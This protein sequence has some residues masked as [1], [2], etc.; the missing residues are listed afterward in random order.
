[1]KQ[2]QSRTV[3]AG[4]DATTDAQIPEWFADAKRRQNVTVPERF[5]AGGDHETNLPA[6]SNQEQTDLETDG[7]T[8]NANAN[9]NTNADDDVGAHIPTFAE[10]I[11][12]LPR[13]T[14]TEVAY[15]N[16]LTGEW[17]ETNRFTALVDPE[18]IEEQ[19]RKAGVSDEADGD[20][21]AGDDPLFHVPS[22]NYTIINPSQVYSP[23]ETVLRDEEYDDGT[24]N[25]V[26]LGDIVFGEIRQYRRGGEVHMDLMFNGMDVD[27]P[28]RARDADSGG[29]AAGST[30]P[31]TMGLTT[32]YDFFGGQAVYVEG[33]AQDGYCSNSIRSL[34]DKQVVRH[35][36]EVNDFTEWWEAILEEVQLLSN[37]L[38]DLIIDAQEITVDFREVPFGVTDL[39]ELL[40]LPDYLAAR[41][42]DD[43]RANAADPFEMD[44]W[45][46]Y[47]GGTY[48]LSHFYRGREGNTLDA[49]SRTINDLLMN[50]AVSVSRIKDA[51]ITREANRDDEQDSLDA[52]GLKAATADIEKLET[53]VQQ[54]ADEYNERQEQ[55]RQ[56]LTQINGDDAG[57][58]NGNGNG[59]A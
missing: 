13:A 4:L 28:E 40:D 44:L 47:S 18:R 35:F 22:H 52:E 39:Y 27:L 21:S 32:G 3:F 41:A 11:R 9:A 29:H 46:L 42:A 31:L 15:R 19:S 8:A 10:A 7:G 30:A 53:S 49:H 2:P 34:T 26:S 1:M 43:A 45:T 59:G 38:Y 54:K 36:G 17:V 16:P 33:F 51:Y 24:G 37:D 25:S 55:I 14:D 20:V 57:N 6:G 48:A 58:G 23:L 50:P 56:R 12:A 5:I